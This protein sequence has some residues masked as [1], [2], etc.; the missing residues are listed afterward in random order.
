VRKLQIIGA[1]IVAA[2]LT[3]TAVSATAG[4][5]AHS[6]R[7]ANL[8]KTAAAAGQFKTLVSLV[9][10]AGLAPALSSKTQLTVFAPTDR[11][12]SK[13]PAETLAELKADPAKLRAVLLYH[14]VK[15]RLPA[16]KVVKLRSAKTLNGAKVK[17]RV[18]R[19]KVFVNSARVLKADV[20]ASNG[21]IHVVNSVLIP[22]AA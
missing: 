18:T 16:A 19:G 6:K 20:R 13:V 17:I 7:K 5:S 1:V 11:A 12:F 9:K 22:P 10:A 15:G 4:T 21:I 2:V 8:V 14:V 3:A